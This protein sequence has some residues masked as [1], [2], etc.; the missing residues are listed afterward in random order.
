VDPP[1][2]SGGSS[3]AMSLRIDLTGWYTEIDARTSYSTYDW[4]SIT[5]T[6]ALS[7]QTRFVDIRFAFAR[8]SG[9]SANAF[10][11][12]VSLQLNR[13]GSVG[14]SAVPEPGTLALVSMAALGL[15]A[16]PR[17][18]PKP[19]MLFARLDPFAPGS[20]RL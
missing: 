19:L 5:H 2:T 6:L 12:N 8:S 18:A 14:P 11:D 20:V 13:T 9:D 16:S 17:R 3:K 7:G 1:T 4:S 15:L 10:V